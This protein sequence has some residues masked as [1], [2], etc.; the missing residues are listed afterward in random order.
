VTQNSV[1]EVE[2]LV[3]LM[4]GKEALER[5]SGLHP[6]EKELPEHCSG[7]FHYKNTPWF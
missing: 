4:P 6:S 2:V 7:V 1:G 3:I 5:C